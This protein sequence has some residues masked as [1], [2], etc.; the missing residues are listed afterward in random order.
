M[1]E[2]PDT[3]M[4]YIVGTEKLEAMQ[5]DFAADLEH[6]ATRARQWQQRLREA[7]PLPA[8]LPP[9]APGPDTQP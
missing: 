3:W 8:S 1:P 6:A 5:A 4:Q 7:E 2:I 9:W